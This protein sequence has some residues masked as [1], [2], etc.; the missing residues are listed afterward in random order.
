MAAVRV[1]AKK[2]QAEF[3]EEVKQ[4]GKGEYEVIG[5]YINNRTKIKI[6]HKICGHI[7]DVLPSAFLQGKR[8][9]NCVHHKNNHD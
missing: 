4:L 6:R 9:P 2:T 7:Y 8:C 1:N 5:N 3:E